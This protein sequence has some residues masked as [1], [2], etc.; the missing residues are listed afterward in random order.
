MGKNN[1]NVVGYIRVSSTM[2]ETNGYSL[3]EQ[4]RIIRDEITSRGLTL[5]KM[6]TDSVSGATIEKRDGLRQL[7]T[8]AK[9]GLFNKVFVAVY[10]RLSRDEFEGLFIEKELLKF[11]VEVISVRQDLSGVPEEY[12]TLMRTLIYSFASI[13]RKMITKRTMAGKAEKFNQSGGHVCGRVSYG[14]KAV[15]DRGDRRIIKVPDEQQVLAKMKRW[16]REGLSYAKIADKL[17]AAKIKPRADKRA[18]TYSGKWTARK[19][20]TALN[21]NMSRGYT[22]FQGEKKKANFK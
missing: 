22:S 5:E 21:S 1:Q 2:Q 9:Q 18:S 7:L 15:G 10:D 17:N 16:R 20:D 8:D 11:G 6:Y 12:R 4:E 13:E 19:V 3:H 14:F